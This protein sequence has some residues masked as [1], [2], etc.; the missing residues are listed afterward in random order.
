MTVK[1]HQVHVRTRD[2]VGK[3]LTEPLITV[4]TSQVVRQTGNVLYTE[5][6]AFKIKREGVIRCKYGQ[7]GRAWTS[8]AE[9]ISSIVTGILQER[10][11]VVKSYSNPTQE[12]NMI[13]RAI[14]H[15]N[16]NYE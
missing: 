8:K 12:I 14:K 11:K 4:Q 1:V 2:Q 3:V 6:N 15:G 10:L 9:D 7:D 5:G 13:E 16:W